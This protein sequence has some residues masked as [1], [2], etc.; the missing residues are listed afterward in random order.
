MAATVMADLVVARGSD[1]RVLEPVERALAGE[2]GAALAAAPQLAGS[3]REHR[4][5]AQLVVV[6]EILIAQRDADTRCT[7]MLSTVCSTCP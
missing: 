1:R 5:M 3:G 2:R 7:T 4:V 6:D